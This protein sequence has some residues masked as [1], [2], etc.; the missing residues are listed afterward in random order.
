MFPLAFGLVP[1]EHI[2]NV[3]EFIKTRGMACSVYGAQHLMDGLYGNGQAS[4]AAAEYAFSLLT[5]TN[6][7]SWAHMIYDVGSTISL[8]AWDNKYKENQD[9]NH[10]WGAAPANVIPRLLMGIEPLNPG[11][12]RIQMR[13]QLGSL[14]FASVTVPTIRGS[15]KLDVQQDAKTWRAFVTIPAN[16]LAEFHF[17]TNHPDR[18]TESGAST[19]KSKWLKFLRTENG[20][21]VFE[22]ASGSYQFEI[23]R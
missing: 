21:S 3:V 12:G 5:A 10:A 1:S 23:Q 15:V 6:D 13:P 17:P 8:E 18:I 22:V 20:A 14:Q 11:F 19:E 2:G 16:T 7:R 9:W 4:P